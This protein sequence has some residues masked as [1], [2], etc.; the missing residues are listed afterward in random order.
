MDAIDF[1]KLVIL[2]ADGWIWQVHENQ[3][4]LGRSVFRLTRPATASI[5]H[6]TEEEWSALRSLLRLYEQFMDQAFDPDRYNYAQLGNEYPRL[7]VHAVPR[8]RGPRAWGGH[9]FTDG[10]W[11]Q[12]WPPTPPSP[13]SLP[14]T[15]DFARWMEQAVNGFMK[16]R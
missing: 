9:Q 16:A 3:S 15:Y 10:R 4:Y 14:E 5:A 8:Y 12:N 1:E 7:H 11:G 6:C 13:L 2:P